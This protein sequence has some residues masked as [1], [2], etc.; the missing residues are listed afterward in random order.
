MLI[1]L[2][3]GTTHEGWLGV[4]V[5]PE[6]RARLRLLHRYIRPDDLAEDGIERDPHITVAFGLDK[7]LPED[8]VS[9]LLKL[10]RGARI[11]LGGLNMFQNP[12]SDVLKFD[13]D[14]EDLQRIHKQIEKEIG[15]PGKTFK[16]YN[17]HV[18]VAY[19]KKG[20][21]LEKYKA[22]ERMLKGKEFQADKIR[23]TLGDNKY[24]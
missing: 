21:K 2:A 13:V 23:L 9:Q 16:D 3:S 4:N 7:E 20:S 14:S 19:L 1:K 17:P 18:S 8:K 24:E 22:L 12:D 6:L 10:P 11:K 15:I 5:P